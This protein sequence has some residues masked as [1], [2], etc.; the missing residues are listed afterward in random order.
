[1]GRKK[2]EDRT[3]VL[4]HR[5]RTRVDDKAF[6]RLSEMVKSSNCNTVGQLARKILSQNRIKVYRK[7]KSLEEP[8]QQLVQ[9]RNELRAI[10]VNITQVTRYFHALEARNR[11][12]FDAL[13]VEETYR[14]VDDKV[15]TLVAMVAKL[16][17]KWLRR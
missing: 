14:E 12:M 6:S 5:I 8:V 7:N 15:T 11:K 1:M 17:E 9:I 3:M 16:G 13:K 4:T 10:Q 2:I